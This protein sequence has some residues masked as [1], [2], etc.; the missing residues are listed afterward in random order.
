LTVLSALN[1]R[2]VVVATQKKHR[3]AR[4]WL[5][6]LLHWAR[7]SLRLKRSASHPI[8]ALHGA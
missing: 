6:V 8:A 7:P 4:R 1:G 3:V 5:A 2:A